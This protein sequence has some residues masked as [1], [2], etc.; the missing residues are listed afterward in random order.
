MKFKNHHSESHPSTYFSSRSADDKLFATTPRNSYHG[1]NDVAFSAPES[2]ARRAAAG[3]FPS[4]KTTDTKWNRSFVRLQMTTQDGPDGNVSENDGDNNNPLVA[5]WNQMRK[6]AARLW[7][8]IVLFSGRFFSTFFNTANGF[9]R[10][11]MQIFILVL[12]CS[13]R[14]IVTT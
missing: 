14:C 2:N 7:V 1:P 6:L 4:K 9:H 5:L 11:V 8:S 3:L 12:L 10:K 13:T